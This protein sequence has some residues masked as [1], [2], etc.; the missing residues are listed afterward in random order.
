MAFSKQQKITFVGL[1]LIQSF[2]TVQA[3][4]PGGL[5]PPKPSYQLPALPR[6]QPTPSDDSIDIQKPEKKTETVS[7][8]DR[9][10]LK[11][12]LFD[13]NKSISHEQ[14]QTVVQPL[15]GKVISRIDLENIRQQLIQHYKKA[16]F[17]Y[18]SVVLPDQHISQGVVR[19]QVYEGKLT[20]INIKGT[21]RLR[22]DYVRDRIK[23]DDDKPLQQTA[24]LERFHMLLSDPLI[25][26]VNGALKPGVNPGDSIL[27]LDI[28][29]AKPYELYLSTDNY[30]PAGVGAYTGHLGGVVRNL[31]GWGD[32]L[33][34]DLSGSEGMQSV[35]SF[36]SLPFT[37]YETR[38]N[39]G[40]QGSQSEIVEGTLAAFGFENR[41]MDFNV[42]L[43][44]PIFRN[45]HRTLSL[46]LQYAFRQTK[47][48]YSNNTPIGL[49]KGVDTNGKAKVS[50]IR[51]IQ[52]HIER[53]DKQVLS[54]RS[55]LNVGFDAF[56]STINPSPTADGRFFSW[57]GQLRYLR[58]ID[59]W[60]TEL[61]FRSDIQLTSES[62]LPL[63][64]FALGGVNTVR[65]YRQNELVRDE[66]YALSIEFRVPLWQQSKK[67]GHDLRVI[68]F[69]D[70]GQVWNHL[71]KSK[72]LYSAGV[73]LKWNWKQLGAEF[74]WAQAL[75]NSDVVNQEY[76][77]QDSGIHFQLQTRLF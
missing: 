17:L 75:N 45:L 1:L 5:N 3:L 60:G 50:V 40:F 57:M 68:P 34:I 35:N 20:R 64:R 42:G 51:F 2:M 49:A 55:S 39:I 29:R 70:Y 65:G 7:S 46:E 43:S 27:D 18:T 24:L 4:E 74:Y 9:I 26:R 44:Q 37:S 38:F 76:D 31:T 11:E 19:Y 59:E 73:G 72:T 10:I 77:L 30:T 8:V 12:V 69:F 56:N 67:D 14:L 28:T 33:K 52:N 13:G 6:W 23:M 71:D 63:E 48:S 22:E 32:F 36:F 54:L 62:L 25:E 16:G 41:F 47:T 66:G 21:E 61:F 53:N 15:V 58:K